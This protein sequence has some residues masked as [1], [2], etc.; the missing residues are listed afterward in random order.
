MHANAPYV[1]ISK[2]AVSSP[3]QPRKNF[4]IKEASH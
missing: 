2:I 4:K 3:S 1:I